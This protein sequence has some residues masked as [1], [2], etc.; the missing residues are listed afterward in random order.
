VAEESFLF[1]SVWL[2]Q[3]HSLTYWRSIDVEQTDP[4]AKR[5]PDTLRDFPHAKSIYRGSGKRMYADIQ[6]RSVHQEAIKGRLA[7][8]R[9]NCGAAFTEKMRFGVLR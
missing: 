6:R 8:C 3:T 4:T 5:L 7:D 1:S 2:A 9:G